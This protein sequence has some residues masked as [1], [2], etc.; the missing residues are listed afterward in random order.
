[1]KVA[2]AGGAGDVGRRLIRALVEA[3]DEVRSLDRNPDHAASVREAGA[4]PV[5]C[6]LERAGLSEITAAIEGVDAVVFS[7][8]AGAGSGPELKWTIDY[9]GA[10]KLI[11]A[12]LLAGVPR[13][14]M[15]SSMGADP[16][17]SGDGTFAVYLRAKGKADEELAKSGLDYTIV[18]P[19]GLTDDP[20]RGLIDAGA[21]VERGKIPRDD[22]AAVLTATLKAKNTIGKTF[23]VTSG[24]T[25]IDEAIAAL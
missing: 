19:S 15:V 22:V 4:E 16:N 23:E 17:A 12:A 20:G 14:V 7:V 5:T 3:G 21:S 18:R 13:Y 24:E 2:I 8:G 10:L 11:A 25:P 1:M 6:D 9:A